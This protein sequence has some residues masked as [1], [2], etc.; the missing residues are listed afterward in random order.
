MIT[1]LYVRMRDGSERAE[2]TV[3]GG[4]LAGMAA[5]F[6]LA[7]AG[8]RVTCIEP[9]T[10][11]KAPVGESLDWSAPA[12]LEVLG[13]S[14]DRLIG[15]KIATYK[16][17]VTVRLMDGS[18]QCYQPD[19]RHYEPGE[20]LAKPPYSIE[21]RT[22]H[23]DRLQLDQALRE[24]VLRQ[25]VEI[26]A[27]RVVEVQKAGRR[28]IAVKAASGR[29]FSS[30]WFI[31]ASGNAR[32]FSRHFRLPVYEYGPT[33]VATWTYL[34]VP[35]SSEGTTLY[36]D[37]QPP[38]MQWIWE[39]PIHSNVISV[40]WVAAGEAIREKRQQ[41]LSVEDIFREQLARIPRFAGLLPAGAIT[42]QV[43]SFQCRVH[44]G[45][46]GPNWLIVGEAASM[47]DPMTANGVTAALRHAG[48]ASALIVRSGR[49]KRLPFLGGA[50][51]NRRIVDLNR[52]FNC[53][54]EN[55]IYA[56]AIRNRIGVLRAGRAYT[57]PAW[58][59]NAV[60]SRIRPQ[61]VV[62]TLLFGFVLN[63]FR[64]ASIVASAFCSRLRGAREAEA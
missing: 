7:R 57:V 46:T 21:L 40:G 51:Y 44:R 39:I 55:T 27:D 6:H 22:L 17:H 38:Y 8:Y 1:F 15:D 35:D 10:G 33:K 25:G 14:M 47:V 12:L 13:L 29:R 9:D 58:V 61:G 49:R 36:M 18:V 31:D 4:G 60:Y 32:L 5:S 37:G 19:T 2:V 59:F 24:I 20:W 50:M 54:I 48:E 11:S 26:A 52:F 42:P 28:V 56:P 41:G 64:A 53:G 34:N 63:L 3:I 23:V 62:S 43:T 45:L 30:D 16:R